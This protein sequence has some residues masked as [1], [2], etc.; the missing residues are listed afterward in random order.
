MKRLGF[1]TILLTVILSSCVKSQFEPTQ[2]AE[3]EEALL[4]LGLAVDEGVQIVQTR[5]DES[6]DSVFPHVD[7]L[8][9][10]LYKYGKK[11]KDGKEYG[12]D[13]WNR[14]YFGQYVQAKDT[15]FRVNAGEWRIMAF[16]GDSTACGF[17]K[18]YVKLDSTF[19]LNGGRDEDGNPNITYINAKAKVSNVRITVEFDES[20]PGSFYDH[21]VRLA[22]IDTSAAAG[23]AS[24]KKY[25]QILRYEKDE[26]RDAYMMPTD[27]L[28]I[29]FMA[30]YEYGAED[31]WRYA[32]LDTVAVNPNDHLKVR[33]SVNPRYGSLDVNITTDNNI[34]KKDNNVEIKEIWTPQ[35]A[36]TIVAAG[37]TDGDHPVVEGDLT[38]NNATVSVLARGGLKNFFLKVESEY[39]TGAGIDV[40]LGV[41]LDLA[42]PT[43]ATQADLDRLNAAGFRWQADML[44][45]RKLTYM[46]MTDLF[47][48]I[49]ELNPSLTVARNL[50]TFTIRVVDEVNKETSVTLT[51]TAYPITQT[52][53]IPE[54]KVWAKKILS[55]ELKVERGVSSLYMLQVSKDGSSWSD[56]KT[57]SVADNSVLDFGTLDVEPSTTYHFRTVYNENPNLMSNVVTVR[58]ED[59]LQ[60]GNSSFEEYQTT[61]MRVEPLLSSAYDREWYLPYYT[62]ESDPWW[63]VNSKKTMPDGHTAWTSGYC[64]NFPCTAYSIDRYDGEKSALVYTINV[65]NANTDGTA[66]GT[67]V[68]G[69]IWIGKADD[70]GNHSVDGHAFASRPSSV[71]FWYKYAPVNSENF[72]VYI[73]LYDASGNEIARSEKL[74]GAAVSKW[75]QCEIPVVYSNILS[76]AAK[77]YMCFKSSVSNEPSVKTGVTM[78]IASKQQ[79]AHI[80]SALRIDNIELVY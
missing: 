78:E 3:G 2:H 25:K 48:R 18:P 71:K 26:T 61:N 62:N 40:P 53:S 22:R 16:H 58:T 5:A 15:T 47:A 28:Q 7:S 23:N 46:T 67:S 36:P 13:G 11:I 17:N 74:D 35:A 32:I 76:R 54:G 65:G 49:N 39:L 56:L 66:V 43:A 4:R 69:E 68:P 14:I 59:L 29:Q 60:V 31:S 64:K 19:T 80:G 77:I 9:V 21:F 79:T 73:A 38:G 1:L 8:Y 30:Q 41:E 57:Y 6:E 70:S 51:S 27:S 50:A 52:L 44:G 75:T 63:A 42:N 45:S 37:F 33:L 24:N 12:K 72:A 10:E 20:V 34:I 55:P